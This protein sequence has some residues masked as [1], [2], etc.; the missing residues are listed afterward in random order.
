MIFAADHRGRFQLSANEGN[1]RR[2]DPTGREYEYD[3]QGELLSWPVAMALSSGMKNYDRNFL[4]GVRAI[5]WAEAKSRE[6]FMSDEFPMALCPSD[7]VKISTPF[8]P[9]DGS[10]RS[11]PPEELNMPPDGNSYWGRLSYGIN[12]DIVGAD[13]GGNQ[14][15]ACWKNGCRGELQPCAGDRLEGNLDRI[16][17]P[18]TCLLLVDAGPDTEEEAGTPPEPGGQGGFANL[19]IS[20]KAAGPTLADFQF[21]W[22]R[23]MPKKRHPKGSVNVL[24]A[25]FHGQTVLP[26]DFYT[27]NEVLSGLPTD[28]NTQVRVSPYRPWITAELDR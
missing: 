28:Y 25:D 10:I 21:Y 12:E 23:R 2:A 5:D 6:S 11:V 20:A 13:A 26:T 24:F 16:Y 14:H 8:Y 27:G 15:P 17:D 4:W 9:R 18:G 22:K 1:I 3:V 7:R 19:I